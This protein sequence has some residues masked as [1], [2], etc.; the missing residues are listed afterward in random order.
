MASAVDMIRAAR[1]G[2]TTV[3]CIAW[4]AVHALTSPGGTLVFSA[5]S[6]VN[7]SARRPV[8]VARIAV[9]CADASGPSGKF[10]HAWIG[11]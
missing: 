8:T 5:Q 4:Q 9:A 3:T 11:R 1:M 10:S 6:P 2:Y 7:A